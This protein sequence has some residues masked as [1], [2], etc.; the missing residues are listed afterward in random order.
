MCDKDHSVCGRRLY[1]GEFGGK[2]NKGKIIL[3]HCYWE[4][5]GTF[6]EMLRIYANNKLMEREIKKAISFTLA[7]KRIKYLGINLNKDVKDLHL[8]NY[9]TLKK[10]IED[11]NKWKHILF[12]RWEEL[13]S[14]KCA[15]YPV[16]LKIPMM[17]STELEQMFQKF[18]WN[19]KRPCIAIAILRKKNKIE[20]LMLPNIKLYYKA[21]EIKTAWYWHKNRHLDKWDRIESTE[22]NPHFYSQYLAE[23]AST[24]NGLKMVYSINAAGKIGQICT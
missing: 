21:I 18:V 19:H 14:L 15:Y 2:K 9:K 3:W 11:T 10:E 12:H 13:T 24:S 20:G 5:R 17:Y 22:I 1:K 6:L 4:K 23:E 16:P 8:E 7:T